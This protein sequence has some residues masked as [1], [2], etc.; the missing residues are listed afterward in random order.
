MVGTLEK[1]SRCIILF[2]LGIIFIMAY[3]PALALQQNP[4][5]DDTVPISRKTET[6]MI[7]DISDRTVIDLD[8][9]NG[10]MTIENGNIKN[11]LSS[12]NSSR[13]QLVAISQI[14]ADFPIDADNAAH[15]ISKNLNGS[16]SKTKITDKTENATEQDPLPN[17]FWFFILGI[18]GILSVRRTMDRSNVT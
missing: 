11:L 10:M 16:P 14:L 5:P 13:Q 17:M 8:R 2:I 9:P 6:P 15:K 3:C 4:H 1:I 12:D 7:G 18:V